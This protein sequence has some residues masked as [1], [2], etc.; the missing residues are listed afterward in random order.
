MALVEVARILDL[1]E[2][3]TAASALRASGIQVFVQNENWGQTEVYLQIG[4]GGFRLWTPEAD[5]ADASAFIAESRRRSEPDAAKVEE[6]P[7][8]TLGAVLLATVAGLLG[9]ALV[10][11]LKR[12]R[13][14]PDHELPQDDGIPQPDG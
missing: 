9:W 7:V 8:V 5:A 6:Y 3:Q 1:T 4:M 14:L 13:P 11:F 12:R 10:P 2:A